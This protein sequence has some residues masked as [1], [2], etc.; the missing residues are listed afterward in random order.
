ML[1]VAILAMAMLCATA[2]AAQPSDDVSVSRRTLGGS[3]AVGKASYS[4][5][6]AYPQIEGG[7]ADFSGLNARFADEAQKQASGAVPCKTCGIDRKQQWDYEQEF[8][9]DR[10]GRRSILITLDA[11]GY[12]GGA[13]PNS[14]RTCILVDLRT[15]RAAGPAE[16]FRSGDGW[17]NALAPLVRTDL[18][19]QFTDG[20]PGNERALEP[21]PLAELLR[22]PSIYC[23]GREALTLHFS[24]Y[25]VGPYVSGPFEVEIPWA[26][27]QPW[28]APDGPLG[29]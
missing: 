29:E 4:Y 8:T 28:I 22:T 15:G 10:P 19:R 23:W 20:K 11:G 21:K 27:L 13:H 25:A 12:S 9:V 1:R 6:I 17:L 5:A 7:K 14:A 26:T 3:G 18:K 16:I 24:P 2:V